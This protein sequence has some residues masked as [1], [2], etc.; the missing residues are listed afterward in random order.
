[1]KEV[2]TGGGTVRG[3]TEDELNGLEIE[4][5]N[6]IAIAVTKDLSAG[7]NSYR[8]LARWMGFY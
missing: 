7:D 3:F 6:K 2:S 4:I 8:R 1:M 5:C